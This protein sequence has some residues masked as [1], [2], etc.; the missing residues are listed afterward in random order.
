MR[1][2]DDGKRGCWRQSRDLFRTASW[3]LGIRQQVESE[4]KSR[5]KSQQTRGRTC[6]ENMVT[7][8]SRKSAQGASQRVGDSG[9]KIQKKNGQS[10]GFLSSISRDRRTKNKSSRGRQEKGTAELCAASSLR[11]CSL[12]SSLLSLFALP[13]VCRFYPSIHSSFIHSRTHSF[14]H[15]LLPSLAAGFNPLYRNL[16][17]PFS[18]LFAH[19]LEQQQREQQEQRHPTPSKARRDSRSLSVSVLSALPSLFALSVAPPLSLFA[20]PSHF[21]TL[22]IPFPDRANCSQL[23]LPQQ[24]P[25][26]YRQSLS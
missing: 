13:C 15:S 14:I 21:S 18:L 23:S 1:L 11:C 22:Y 10:R 8:T 17:A 5:E 2:C 3:S 7:Q 6:V 9:R 19:Q 24:Q 25:S 4:R 12:L 26:G 20:A 16:D